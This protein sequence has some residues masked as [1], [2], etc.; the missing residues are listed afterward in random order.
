MSP[1]ILLLQARRLGDPVALEERD[2]FAA[3]AGLPA[4]QFV[5]HDLLQGP[6]KLGHVRRHD[7]LMVGGSGDFYVSKRNLPGFEDLLGMLVDV[8]DAGH[9]MFASCFGFQCLVAALGGEIVHDSENTEVGTY[10]LALT[11]AGREDPLLSA[12]PVEFMAQLGRK[13]RAAR[14]PEGVPNL[15]ASRRSPYQAF[16]IPGSPIWAT[17]FHPELDGRENLKRFRQYL[18]GYSERMD[19]EKRR[20]ALDRF[21]ASPETPVLIPRFLDLIR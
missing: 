20:R 17:Q 16:R 15:A 9:P 21:E 10:R 3:K 8:V 18:D 4:E 14:L 5:L 11:E 19:P 6:P 1:K 13:D 7:A 12:L 2:S